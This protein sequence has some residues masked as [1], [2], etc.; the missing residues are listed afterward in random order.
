MLG[1]APGALRGERGGA[2]PHERRRHV[3]AG[4]EPEHAGQ[5]E[6]GRGS[7]EAP[8]VPVVEVA[9]AR[10]RDPGGPGLAPRPRAHGHGGSGGQLGAR[11]HRRDPALARPRH[12]ADGVLVRR[13]RERLVQRVVGGSGLVDLGLVDRR[14][15]GRGQRREDRSPR[16]LREAARRA[17][18]A[19]LGDGALGGVDESLEDM[20][21]NLPLDRPGV[22][23]DVLVDWRYSQRSPGAPSPGRER[24]PSFAR[25]ELQGR[26]A[27]ITGGA[28][29]I[30]RGLAEAFVAAGARGVVIADLDSERVEAVAA[31][32]GATGVAVDVGSEPEL[33]GVSSR[34][35]SAA[36][37]STCS[38]RTPA[39]TAPSAG[40]RSPTRRGDRIWRINV[41]VARGGRRGRCCPRC[42]PAARATCST[43]RRPRACSPTSASSP[44]SVT[45]HAAVGVAEWLAITYGDDGNP[46]S[47]ACAPSSSTRRWPRRSRASRG[48]SARWP[49]PVSCSRPRTSRPS[50]STRSGARSS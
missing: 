21:C 4:P 50:S 44:Y 2:R 41:D 9:A 37:R 22:D 42:S 28:S 11:E 23:P 10:E 18:P 38:A 30:G 32:I 43:P 8:G 26:R 7:G 35:C 27:V 5:P 45:K 15:G 49:R 31:E 1:P 13:Y 3:V 12:R 40:P 48:S 46:A 14:Q 20:A 25:M 16:A 34:S 47:P 29:G 17:L 24:S 36:G 39:S 6:G 33:N 19:M